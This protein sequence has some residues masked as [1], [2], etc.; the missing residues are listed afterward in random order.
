MKVKSAIL[1]EVI[2]GAVILAVVFGGVISVLVSVRQHIGR[3]NRRMAAVNILRSG[4]SF[5][6]FYVRND[7]I[8]TEWLA[9]GFHQ[10][11]D[12]TLD[13]LVY[14]SNYTVNI[15]PEAGCEYRQVTAT[16]VYP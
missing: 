2:I 6:D 5:L 15:T 16:V 10:F 7:T 3:S 9:S 14:T 12:T 4:L 1:T 13:G 11:N 8:D